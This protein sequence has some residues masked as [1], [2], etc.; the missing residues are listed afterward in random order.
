[1]TLKDIK[2][3]DSAIIKKVIANG[4]IKRRLL[5]IGLTPGTKIECVLENPGKNLIAYMIRGS[6]IAIRDE[7]I[8]NILIEAM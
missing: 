7:D 6:L 2:I 8:E 5:D 4:N 1:M 3:G